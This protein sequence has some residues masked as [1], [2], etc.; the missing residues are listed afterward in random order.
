[1]ARLRC[2][3]RNTHD[4]K[5]DA[6]Q[7]GRYTCTQCGSSIKSKQDR[8]GGSYKAGD[9]VGGQDDSLLRD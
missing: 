3:F 7:A 5:P 4:W 9:T 8:E 6:A 1:M 2:A